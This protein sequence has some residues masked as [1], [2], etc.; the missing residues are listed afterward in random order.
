MQTDH[1]GKK[2]IG[3]KFFVGETPMGELAKKVFEAFG[4]RA[5]GPA[6]A[7]PSDGRKEI[8]NE[9]KRLLKSCQ[10]GG[11]RILALPADVVSG[12]PCPQCGSKERC[13]WLDGRL[14]CRSCLMQGN[15]PIVA[16]KVW[17]DA[18]E[19]AIWV[20]ADD[21][22]KQEWPTDAPVYTHQEVKQLIQVGPQALAWVHVTK[23]MFGA[24][25]IDGRHRQQAS[26]PSTTTEGFTSASE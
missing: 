17:S 7:P 23:A 14:I 3:N 11:D 18:L 19:A 8:S 20:I 10:Q 22:P 6:N 24:Q 4:A 12:E 2:G 26:A 25:V 16:V 13:R 5:S 21:L 15:E 9:D 1:V